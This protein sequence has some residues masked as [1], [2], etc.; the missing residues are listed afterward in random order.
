METND[1]R[2]WIRPVRARLGKAK[3]LRLMLIGFMFGIGAAVLWLLLCRFVPVPHYRLI[4]AAFAALGLLGGAALA[5]VRWPTEAEAAREMDRHGLEESVS[6]ALAFIE[7]DSPVIRLQREQAIEQAKRFAERIAQTI[8]LHAD[9]KAWIGAAA[10]AC[11]FAALWAWPNPQDAVMEQRRAERDWI[12]EQTEIAA[13]FGRELAGQPNTDAAKELAG[14]VGDLQRSLQR[15]DNGLNALIEMERA[16]ARMQEQ[17]ERL[18]KERMKLAEWAELLSDAP[19]LQPLSAALAQREEDALAEAMDHLQE[20]LSA[21]TPRQRELFARQVEHFAAEATAPD[22][23]TEKQLRDALKR[24]AESQLPAGQQGAAA[25]GTGAGGAQSHNGGADA[26]DEPSANSGAGAAGGV[27]EEAALAQLKEALRKSIAEQKA[28]DA[29]REQ[30]KRFTAQL[31]QTGRKMAERMTASGSM[32][33]AAWLPDGAASALAGFT[34]GTPGNADSGGP[35]SGMGAATGAGAGSTTGASGN[36]GSPGTSAGFGQSG[37]SGGPGGN[38]GAGSGTGGA[39]GAS[40]GAGQGGASGGSGQGEAAGHAGQSGA[41]GRSGNN[42]GAGSNGVAETSGSTGQS[43]GSG[44]GSGGSAGGTGDGSR[45]LVSTPRTIEGSGD[46]YSDPGPID[47]SG[48]G[49]GMS[50]PAAATAGI[51]RNYEEVYFEYAQEAVDSLDR[52]SLPQ[53][54]KNLVRDYFLEIQPDR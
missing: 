36:A 2:H 17:A 12:G 53:N 40:G 25:G 48:E 26:T 6:T 45:A 43:G 16:L 49:T 10:G 21:M 7:D 52:S 22:A 34:A 35:G 50:E 23:A 42:S 29:L 38:S 31:A 47:G 11:L 15:S 46:M 51:S 39:A 3:L 28:N 20:A 33:P 27:T 9:R 37:T 19:A 4:A 18:E 14:I 8:P 24:L 30:Q 1:L 41:A 54:M 44:S 13:E 32:P 5:A